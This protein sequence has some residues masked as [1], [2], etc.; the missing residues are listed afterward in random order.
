M[1]SSTS[2]LMA[3]APSLDAPFTFDD[4][5]NITLNPGIR[6]DPGAGVGLLDL[7]LW[8]PTPRPVS[9]LSFALNY[10]AGGF[11]VRG[12]R[13]V[14]IAVHVVT[15]L[16]VMWLAWQL[17]G[18]L[19]GFGT[20]GTW[21]V[22]TALLRAGFSVFAGLVF[23]AHPLATQSVTYV[24]Q[25]MTSL[26]TLFYVAALCVW[27]AGG[28][29]SS[30]GRGARRGYRLCAV[31]LWLLS[32]GS[33][34]IAA[35]WPVVVWLW[36]WQWLRSGE[37]SRAFARRSVVWGLGFG[38]LGGVAVW[39]YSGGDPLGGYASKPFTLWERLWTEPRV[40]WRYVG[41]VVWP[42]PCSWSQRWQSPPCNAMKSGRHPR[43]CGAT[44]R[45]RRP[46]APKHTRT[47]AS[48]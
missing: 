40:W 11:E 16:L 48:H 31:V 5:N 44:P 25:R 36:E 23:V 17:L 15:S 9:N 2:Q 39:A 10:A 45:A 30:Q 47:S 3:Y 1:P 38:V 14:N 28:E 35:T 8:G 20:S 42:L 27:M 13:S 41:L 24:V 43:R 19:G 18:R 4:E 26:S 32:L 7:R 29:S 6:L 33:K 34:E 12:Y 46:S 21:V 22:E 37:A